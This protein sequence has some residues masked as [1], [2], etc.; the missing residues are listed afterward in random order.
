MGEGIKLIKDSDNLASYLKAD[1]LLK[2][3]FLS[4]K[5]YL[6]DRY[7]LEFYIINKNPL[8]DLESLRIIVDGDSSKTPSNISITAIADENLVTINKTTQYPINNIEKDLL[9]KHRD[10][11]SKNRR[12]ETT[13]IKL[14]SESDF[15][16]FCSLKNIRD[17]LR[18]YGKLNLI[19]YDSLNNLTNHVTQIFN[20]IDRVIAHNLKDIKPPTLVRETTAVASTINNDL[21]LAV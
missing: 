18:V 13:N 5:D 11:Q 10:V 9:A 7:H 1:H 15:Q 2:K 4:G 8:E 19:G 16:K 17:E 21:R 6:P 20:D 3:R 14:S 12:F